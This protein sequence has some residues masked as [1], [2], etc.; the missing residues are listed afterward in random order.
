M[1]TSVNSSIVTTR[2][3]DRNSTHMCKGQYKFGKT[4]VS[5]Y[6]Q[7][8]CFVWWPRN[9]MDIKMKWNEKEQREMKLILN[10]FKVFVLI[11]KGNL[12]SRLQLP[13]QT[14]WLSFHITDR[15]SHNTLVTLEPLLSN[16]KGTCTDFSICRRSRSSQILNALSIN[17][18]STYDV[19]SCRNAKWED[20]VH[21]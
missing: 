19:F 20:S 6:L 9:E 2:N 15:S 14:V 7:R 10:P 5:Y 3:I 21:S 12:P 4:F 17:F 11:S 1:L 13:K 16:G 8:N 18:S